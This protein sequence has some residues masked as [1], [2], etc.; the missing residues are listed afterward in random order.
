MATEI[1]VRV[2]Q[3]TLPGNNWLIVEVVLLLSALVGMG[4][5]TLVYPFH[6]RSRLGMTPVTSSMPRL[7]TTT[8][9]SAVA[10]L[11]MLVGLTFGELAGGGA[12]SIGLYQP[13]VV[14]AQTARHLQWL[15]LA[16]AVGLVFVAT[17]VVTQ[18]WSLRLGTIATF[19]ILSGEAC[20]LLLFLCLHN[21]SAVVGLMLFQLVVGN[22]VLS[23]DLWQS[24]PGDDLSPREEERWL[25]HHQGNM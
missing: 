8:I 19:C 6:G 21:T 18:P 2:M 7:Q 3:L 13:T 11:S 15:W 20:T 9:L 25:E 12:P 4:S 14:L 22:V 5:S 23:T 10:A 16:A 17:A 24:E 1:Y